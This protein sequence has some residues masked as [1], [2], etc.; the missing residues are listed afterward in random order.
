MLVGFPF[1]RE[2]WRHTG[3]CRWSVDGVDAATGSH[4]IDTATPAY[5]E[6]TDAFAHDSEDLKRSPNRDANCG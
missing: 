3:R 6:K 5:S 4:R 1:R 2:Y